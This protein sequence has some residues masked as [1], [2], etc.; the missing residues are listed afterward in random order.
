MVRGSWVKK[1]TRSVEDGIP[2]QERGNENLAALQSCLITP[3]FAGGTEPSAPHQNL[4]VGLVWVVC[5][6]RK[7]RSKG[8][9]SDSLPDVSNQEPRPKQLEFAKENS[10]RTRGQLL[11]FVFLCAKSRSSNGA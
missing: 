1:T 11:I 9:E 6:S 8:A 2:T 4:R 3:Q 7:N 10:G 5:N